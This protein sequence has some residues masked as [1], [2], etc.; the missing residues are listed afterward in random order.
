MDVITWTSLISGSV[1]NFKY[2]RART[3]LQSMMS[4]GAR[5]LPSSATIARIL[6]ASANAAEV[7]R[8]KAMVTPSWP[9][10]SK[11]SQ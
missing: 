3:L 5:S 4:A 1:L 8:G 6:P 9:V 2:D 7:K 10:S 11:T